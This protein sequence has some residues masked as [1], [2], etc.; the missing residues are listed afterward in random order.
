[1]EN[2]LESN[3]TMMQNNTTKVPRQYGPKDNSNRCKR[4]RWFT[5]MELHSELKTYNNNPPNVEN[6]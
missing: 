3:I 2:V 1:M 4:P 5:F 6:K